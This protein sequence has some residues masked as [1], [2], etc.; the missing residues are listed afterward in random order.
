M[1]WNT[2]TALLTDWLGAPSRVPPCGRSTPHKN[3]MPIVTIA[4]PN[5]QTNFAQRKRISELIAEMNE[6]NSNWDIL[7]YEQRRDY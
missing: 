4:S 5:T 2:Y 7:L 6:L 3:M 1:S